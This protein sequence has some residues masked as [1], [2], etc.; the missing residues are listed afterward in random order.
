MRAYRSM[1]RVCYKKVRSTLFKIP[2][3]LISNSIDLFLGC[4]LFTL[5]SVNLCRKYTSIFDLL[6][7]M[8]VSKYWFILNWNDFRRIQRAM[9]AH[10]SQMIWFRRLYIY[11]SR[12]MV[13]NTLREMQLSDAE[14]E[15]QLQTAQRGWT[16][17]VLT[18]TN[19]LPKWMEV[20][21][22]LFGFSCQIDKYLSGTEFIGMEVKRWMNKPRTFFSSCNNELGDH[23]SRLVDV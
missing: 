12:Y 3:S 7:S 22:R 10:Q 13:I 2:I 19:M 17:A 23:C 21:F 1:W 20:A 18:Q 8:T 6:L 14:L 4:R 9:Y 16:F 15:M 5:D 11:F